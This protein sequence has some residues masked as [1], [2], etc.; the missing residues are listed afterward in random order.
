M[1]HP[2]IPCEGPTSVLSRSRPLALGH[3]V[4]AV[5]T[6]AT[7]SGDVGPWP[8]GRMDWK[9]SVTPLR[10]DVTSGVIRWTCLRYLAQLEVIFRPIGQDCLPLLFF[11]VPNVLTGGSRY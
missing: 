8:I 5:L 1:T 11:Y 2:V 3:G 10:V 9:Y 4:D 6:A 7:D